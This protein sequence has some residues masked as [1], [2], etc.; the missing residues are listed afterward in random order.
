MPH[1]ACIELLASGHGG[2]RLGGKASRRDYMGDSFLFR[3]ACEVVRHHFCT[4]HRLMI[5]GCWYQGSGVGGDLGKCI[6][7]IY[8]HV[9]CFH[10]V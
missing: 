9:I 7:I 1:A 5:D 10:Y 8:M 6:L 4:T 3:S 2:V